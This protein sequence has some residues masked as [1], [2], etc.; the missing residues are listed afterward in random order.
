MLWWKTLHSAGR[1]LWGYGQNKFAL[2]YSY[3]KL[4]KQSSNAAMNAAII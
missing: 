4:I 3:W 1:T 2:S